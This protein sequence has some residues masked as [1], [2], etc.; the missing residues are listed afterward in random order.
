MEASRAVPPAAAQAPQPRALL[1]AADRAFEQLYRS[2]AADIYRYAL[3][4]LGNPADAEDV[5]QTTFLNAYR[6]FRRGQRPLQPH[7]WLV[8]IAHN[9]CRMRWRQ[10]G[11][12]PR[13]IALENAPE[14]AAPE[15]DH[16]DLDEVLQALG[17]LSFNQRSAIV[18]RELEGRSCR[19]IAE[20]LGLTV[21][22]V[23]ALLFR[24][25]KRL[26]LE[27]RELGVISTAPLP[28]QIGSALG[29]GSSGTV[30]AGGAGLG[31]NLLLKTAAVLAIGAATAGT[32]AVARPAVTHQTSATPAIVVSATGARAAAASRAQHHVR[33]VNRAKQTGTRSA[34]RLQ[35][36]QH[37]GPAAQS[38]VV[39]TGT[40]ASGGAGSA[41]APPAAPAPPPLQLPQVPPAAPPAQP[42]LPPVP[43]L[44]PLPP[45]PVL[46]PLPPPPQLP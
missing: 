43:P 23:E 39:A 3:A 22:A 19:E 15:S 11:H 37:Q 40:T 17:R 7:N 16:P 10:A 46:P 36:V 9:V 21:G 8:K 31:A 12:R 45:P 35:R 29:L 30:A 34:G 20:V 2:H 28:A 18:M 26:R 32:V 4:V 1:L 38:V 25:R 44:P 41:P 6:A 14:T 24:A 13:E 5:A 27:R 33:R 42:P